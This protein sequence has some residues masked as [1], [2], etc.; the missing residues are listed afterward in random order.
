MFENA[1]RLARTWQA[2]E[3][4]QQYMEA[5]TLFAAAANHDRSAKSILLAAETAYVAGDQIKARALVERA[6]SDAGPLS[7]DTRIIAYS[8]LALISYQAGKK[9]DVERG[10]RNAQALVTSDASDEALAYF[11]FSSGIYEYFFGDVRKASTSFEEAVRL[12]TDSEEPFVS[13]QSLFYS[14]YSQLRLGNTLPAMNRMQEALARSQQMGYER[15]IAL[16]HREIG[17]IH[18]YLGERQ[19][20]LD[21]FRTAE[22]MF[23]EAGAVVELAR[24]FNAIGLVYRD[25]GDLVAAERYFE[26]AERT[27]VSADYPLGEL[28]ALLNRS[29]LYTRA[30]SNEQARESYLL[31][32]KRAEELGDEFQMSMAAE[33][34]GKLELN[35]K[36]FDKAIIH[37]KAALALTETSGTNSNTISELLGAAYELKGDLKNARTQYDSVLAINDRT[38]NTVNRA[39]NL[40]DL[41]RVDYLEGKFQASHDR[42]V[43]SLE[44]TETVYASVDSSS[45]RRSYLGQ[46]HYRFELMTAL[47]ARDAIAS[48][49]PEDNELALMYLEKARSR[50]LS[51]D[52]RLTGA[53]FSTDADQALISKER[54]L[55]ASLTAKNDRLT[56]MRLEDPSDPDVSV[57]E[58]EIS[59]ILEEL[60]EIS[61]V[62]KQRDPLYSSIRKPPDFELAPLQR[63]A[64]GSDEVLIV[65][66]LSESESYV[67]L[68]DK[69]KI[70]LYRLPGGGLINQAVDSLNEKL[71]MRADVDDLQPEKR[72][73]RIR[74]ADADYAVAARELSNMILGP[75]AEKIKGKRLIVVPDGKLNYFPISALPMPNSESDDPIL[76]TNE[77]IYQPSAQTYALLK[78]IGKGRKDERTRDLLVFSDPVFNP[79]D[80]RLT[81]V[82]V[83]AEKPDE[84]QYRFRLVESFSSLSRLPASKTEAETVSSAVGGSDLFMGFDAT[85]D[86]LLNTNLSDY[87]VVH[88]AT[89]GFLDPERPELSS[90]VFSRYDQTGKQIDESIRMHDIYSMKLNADLV[91]LS[92]CQTGTGKEIKGEGVMGL[93]TAFLQ[94][95]ARSVVSTLWQVE[96]NAANQLMKEFYGRMV[97]DGMSP[98]AALRAAQI[99]LYQDP[100]FRSPFFWAAFTVHGDAATATPFKR[101]H[102][103]LVISISAAVALGLVGFILLR[104]RRYRTS[105]V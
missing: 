16:A 12:S 100:Q 44:L 21:S 52:L 46:S 75:V 34:L 54:Y 89:H 41:A 17:Y 1:R 59:K 55:L 25:F 51:E 88:L 42:M 78:K 6:I 39:K 92:A 86:R 23:P 38:G 40:F 3:A 5:A 61:T 18:F 77:V 27:F 7:S 47:A 101:D 81:G 14:G 49:S 37:F 96:D 11:H 35:S 66:F 19:T 67:W 76:L 10:L 103:K 105:K 97:S 102:T 90:L 85:R 26:D 98:S 50:S 33:G 99:K 95:G 74:T 36:N 32:Q 22:R 56:N 91:V 43:E 4:V 72:A 80:E 15:G 93:N 48:L 20:A 87:R 68:A 65:Y 9:A 2:N 45:L 29:D 58:S 83:A 60:D 57:V 104:R 8:I 30:G 71:Q 70:E 84:Q 28:T 94:A 82:E 64:L 62:Q 31:A 24:V 63:E 79:A 53:G 13:T 73:E 69:T